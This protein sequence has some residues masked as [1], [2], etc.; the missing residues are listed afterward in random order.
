MLLID[1]LEICMRRFCILRCTLG[2]INLLSLL[3]QIFHIPEIFCFLGILF[4]YFGSHFELLISSNYLVILHII[5][6]FF[7]ENFFTDLC[8]AKD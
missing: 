1:S 5:K 2:T 8:D 4:A 6:V 3:P 7:N